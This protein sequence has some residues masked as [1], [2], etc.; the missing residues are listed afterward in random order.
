[1]N[2][3]PQRQCFY[4]ITYY[5]Y[6]QPKYQKMLIYVHNGSVAIKNVMIVIMLNE[7]F[8]FLI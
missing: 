7:Y 6:F 2:E 4:F 5:T 3:Y 1:M 8:P